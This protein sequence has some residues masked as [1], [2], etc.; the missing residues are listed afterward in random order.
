MSGQQAC[1]LNQLESFLL[2]RIPL[3]LLYY[4]VNGINVYGALP[5]KSKVAHRTYTSLLVVGGIQPWF[6]NLGAP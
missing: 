6:S 3:K 2:S 1:K 5:P 4:Q